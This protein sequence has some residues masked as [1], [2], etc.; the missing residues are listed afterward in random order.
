MSLYSKRY[1]VI[2]SK[3]DEIYWFL[4]IHY[5]ILESC[6]W[7]HYHGTLLFNSLY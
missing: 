4:D 1:F 6:D 7:I 3:K 5:P 2:Y